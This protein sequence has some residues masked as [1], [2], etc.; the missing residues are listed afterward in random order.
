MTT[1]FR[2]LSALAFLALLQACGGGSTGNS[3]TPLPPTPPTPPTPPVV[4]NVSAGAYSGTVAGADWFSVLLPDTAFTNWY[5]LHFI[6]G[7]ADLYSGKFT[8]VGTATATATSGSLA[9]FPY[10]TT[11]GAG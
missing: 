1:T 9:L 6:G 10:A 11:A 2:A 3:G 4:H 7:N 5:A 8:G